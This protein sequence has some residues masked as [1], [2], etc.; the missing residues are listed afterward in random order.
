MTVQNADLPTTYG[1]FGNEDRSQ[2]LWGYGPWVASNQTPFKM[3][4]DP[5]GTRNMARDSRVVFQIFIAGVSAGTNR[6]NTTQSGF[7][8]QVS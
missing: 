1:E 4:F 3:K 6:L 2:Y 5:K 7:V 8:T